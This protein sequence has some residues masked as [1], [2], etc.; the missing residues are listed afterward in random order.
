MRLDQDLDQ[1]ITQLGAAK[2]WHA[3]ALE[4]HHLTCLD[5]RRNGH[6]EGAAVWERDAFLGAVHRLEEIDL[7]PVLRVLSAHGE[8]LTAGAARTASS[9]EQ[10]AEQIGEAAK[11]LV[12]GSR[13]VARSILPAGIFA[14]V[15]LLRTLLPARVDLASVIAAP[16]LGIAKNVVG[17][18]HLLEFVLGRLV[19]RIE[20][21]MQ[22]LGE[23]AIGLGDVLSL[24]GARHAEN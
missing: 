15:T 20:V 17:G 6:V 13:A 8:A 18:S 1:R 14:I 2:A 11:I 9:A 12:T 16:L 7:E 23:L 19:S 21:G 24:R 3:L 4:P 5:P 22:L 10:I